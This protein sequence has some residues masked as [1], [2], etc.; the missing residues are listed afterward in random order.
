MKQT[1]VTREKTKTG[2][3]DT[4]AVRVFTVHFIVPM[5]SFDAATATD[6]ALSNG[7]LTATHTTA[8]ANSGAKVMPA[9]S[10]GKFYFEI[11]LLAGHG[12]FDAMGLITSGTSYNTFGIAGGSNCVAVA[13]GG[14]ININSVANGNLGGFVPNDVCGIAVDLTAHLVWCRRNAGLWNANAGADPAAGTGGLTIIS[15][16]FS[17]CACFVGSGTAINDGYTANFGA[18]AYANAAPSGFVNWPGP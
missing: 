6:T 11:M 5:A 7:N 18:T 17:P 13:R 16:G 9:Q 1:D 4:R 15:A 14:T 2:N 10:A 3:A 12:S 8:N